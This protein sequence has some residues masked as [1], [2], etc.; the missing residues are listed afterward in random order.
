MIGNAKISAIIVG[1]NQARSALFWSAANATPI[2][3]SVSPVKEIVDDEK[4]SLA[5]AVDVMKSFK[6]K[7]RE[8]GY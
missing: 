1:Y 7:K 4:R 5:L 2:V 3:L 8:T 6:D